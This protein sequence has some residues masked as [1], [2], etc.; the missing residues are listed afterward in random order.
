MIKT[1][2]A[3]AALCGG[4]AA[5]PVRRTPVATIAGYDNWQPQ[6]GGYHLFTER[7]NWDTAINRCETAGG[8]LATIH[9]IAVNN[10]LLQ[11]E[12]D[13]GVTG[14]YWIGAHRVSH[15]GGNGDWAWQ[16]LGC[17]CD[18]CDQNCPTQ[19]RFSALED[20]DSDGNADIWIKNE[21]NDFMNRENCVRAGNTGSKDYGRWNDADCSDTK[22]YMCYIERESP[23]RPTPASLLSRRCRLKVPSIHCL[24]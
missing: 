21:P 1:C 15:N 2:V 14:G 19:L 3:L 22:P 23:A 13:A 7:V 12:R 16:S 6:L 11:M 17:A 20:S 8:W 5:G 4:A 24:K 9:S 10:F 18:T